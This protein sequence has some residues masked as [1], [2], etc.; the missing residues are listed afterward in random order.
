MQMGESVAVANA[1]QKAGK[2]VICD[3]DHAAPKKEKIDKTAGKSGWE[4]DK[5]LVGVFD[6]GDAA[7]ASIYPAG[8][9]P[10]PYPTEGHHCLAYT[11][12]VK[13]NKDTCVRLNHF[14]NKTGFKPNDGPNILQLPDRH[15]RSGVS[16][17]T[18]WPAGVKKEYKS[19]WVSVD[20]SK[21]L[22]LHLGRHRG[23]YFLES[24]AL[25][26]QM[27]INAYDPDM[28]KD[29]SLQDF[30]DALKV[31]SK[32]AV[33]FAFIHVSASKWI[34]HPEHLRI[35]RDLYGKTGKHQY[36]YVHGSGRKESQRLVG[37]PGKATT[38]AAW[39]KV[40]LD[41]TPF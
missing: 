32:G 14:L 11:S 20:L 34:C 31:L 4:R 22:Q 17:A 5:S 19:F 25:Y 12:F 3:S 29:E 10:P 9:Y 40:S 7:R 2:C 28:C 8:A 6:S 1:I 23:S 33:N 36:T 15:G 13:R 18:V 26:S 41:T 21:P 16:A 37:Y 38:V 27:M 39:P 35:A 30:E 24:D